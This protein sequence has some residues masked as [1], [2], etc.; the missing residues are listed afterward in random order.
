MTVWVCHTNKGTYE[1]DFLKNSHIGISYGCELDLFTID[2]RAELRE[3]LIENHNTDEGYT[4]LWQFRSNISA[5]D[6]AVVP[7]GDKYHIG[8]VDDIYKYRPGTN[9]QHVRP[10]TWLA[11]DVPEDA[12]QQDS[13]GSK[14][15][16]SINNEPAFHR[17]KAVNAEK[18]VEER[19]RDILLDDYITQAQALFKSGKLDK[20][21][22]Y[23]IAIGQQLA[24]ARKAVLDGNGNWRDLVKKGIAG[25]LIF[26]VTIAKFR[27][28]MDNSPDEALNALREMY[29]EGDRSATE[30]VG[31]FAQ[32]L[33]PSGISA[34]GVRTNVASVLLMGLDAQQHPPFRVGKFDEAYE[35]TGYQ[36]VPDGA[37]EAGLYGHAQGFLDKL[38][39]RTR[40]LEFERPADR[41]EA[42]SV[43]WMMYEKNGD[44]DEDEDTESDTPIYRV[45]DLDAL[46]DELMLDARFLRDIKQLL[47][48]KGQV[49]FQGPPGTGKT[50]VARELAA[51]LA[52][53]DERVRLV[54]FHPSYAYEDFVQGFRPT[55]EDGQA[56]FALRN[57]PLVEMADRARNAP[58]DQKHFLIIDEINRGNI[59]K[60]FGELY[61]LLEY[62]KKEI[63]LQ[64]S[65]KP[66]SLPP[67]LSIIGTMNTADRSIALVDLALRRRFSF[68]EFHPNKEPVKGLLRRW[69]DENAPDMA[70]LA[71]VVDFA[72]ERLNEQ[73]QNREAAIGPSYFMKKETFNGQEIPLDEERVRL[74]WE[75]D[76]LPYVEEQLYGQ[77]DRLKAFELDKMHA[78]AKGTGSETGDA[79]NASEE[80]SED[81][82]GDA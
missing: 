73:L 42:Q 29:A 79:D 26:P 22:S 24:E 19:I 32:R 70:W 46:A 47:N 50:Y 21:E 65:D 1:D 14:I 55:L 58:V 35:R 51:C 3:H 61:F 66:F 68:F 59:A 17:I 40:A 71:D 63:Q 67:N 81:G 37:D 82:S 25:N 34:E 39:E 43:V 57:G 52:G 78:E 74:I 49:I 20:G 4:V 62:R 28:W 53:S 18:E 10:V 11:Q 16:S 41:L 12:F 48:E 64:Y 13:L 2:S 60:V 45:P 36:P 23:K 80:E 27:D 77:R 69:L 30:R 76:V 31:D 44:P 6:L 54:Q 33:L 5:N 72:N 7:I 8:T 38:L 56:G 9:P 15:L 75:H